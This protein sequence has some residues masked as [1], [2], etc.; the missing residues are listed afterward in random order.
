MDHPLQGTWGMIRQGRIHNGEFSSKRNGSPEA[1]LVGGWPTPLKNISKLGWLFIT[2][3][4]EIKV[5]FQTTKQIDI[6]LFK[7]LSTTVNHSY[8]LLTTM[9]WLLVDI[10]LWTTLVNWYDHFQYM[11]KCS[12][13][14]TSISW[15]DIALAH[16]GQ[17]ISMCALSWSK[18]RSGQQKEME[19]QEMWLSPRCRFNKLDQERNSSEKSGMHATK[20]IE[21][22]QHVVAKQKGWFD[23]DTAVQ[24]KPWFQGLSGGLTVNTPRKNM[25]VLTLASFWWQIPLDITRIRKLYS[26]WLPQIYP[27]VN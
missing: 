22:S 12:Q 21:T 19:R 6:T 5:M 4:W 16:K 24:Q 20:N 14:Q 17:A 3:V 23:F 25:A 26:A 7:P 1:I 11:E 13:P 27:R 10:P 2:H 9:N 8:P 15:L 18:V